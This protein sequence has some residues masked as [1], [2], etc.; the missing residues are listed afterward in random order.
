M[1]LPGVSPIMTVDPENIKAL[2]TT[3]FNDFGKGK[4]FH[5]SWELVWI[6]MP[7]PHCF[8]F[9][10]PP[11]LQFCPFFAFRFLFLYIPLLITFSSYCSSLETASS[12]STAKHGPIPVPFSVPNS[13]NKESPILQSLNITSKK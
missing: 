7:L 11:S 10:I 2:L 1:R 12:P 8:H 3:Q 5:D 9:A 4:E 6:P 13:A